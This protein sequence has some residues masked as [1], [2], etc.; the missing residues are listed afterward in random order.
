MA[1]TRAA[2]SYIDPPR[3]RHLSSWMHASTSERG[4]PREALFR[5]LVKWVLAAEPGAHSPR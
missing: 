3:E 1:E 4:Y 5:S 2:H